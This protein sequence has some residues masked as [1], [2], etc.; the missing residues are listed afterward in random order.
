MK[1]FDMFD[2]V[3]CINLD[4]RPDRMIHFEDQVKKYNLGEFERVSA[5]DGK[6]LQISNFNTNLLPGEIG[7]ILS[8]KKILEESI[9]KEYESI[10]IIE[11]D[12]V[13]FEDIKKINH[14]VKYLPTDWDM[15]YFGGNHNLHMGAKPPTSINNFFSKLH[16]TYSAHI[17]GIKKQNYKKILVEIDK[18][19]KPLDVVYCDLQKELNVYSLTNGVTS[20]INN[21]SDIQNKLV[22]Y[23]WLIK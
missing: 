20:Q 17:I 6:E 10:L 23:S 21:Y 12:C 13:F 3:F 22:D 15:L 4:R 7:V 16:S 9:K 11:D 14:Y 19:S 5:I 8:N 18:M 1:L 2:K